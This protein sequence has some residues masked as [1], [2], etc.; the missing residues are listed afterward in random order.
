MFLHFNLFLHHFC[1]SYEAKTVNSSI[2][3]RLDFKEFVFSARLFPTDFIAAFA[4]SSNIWPKDS[5]ALAHRKIWRNLRTWVKKRSWTMFTNMKN[6]GKSEQLWNAKC[7][8]SQTPQNEEKVRQF[9]LFHLH[10]PPPPPP[11]TPPLPAPPP[12][13]AVPPHLLPQTLPVQHPPLLPQ[14]PMMT[15]NMMGRKNCNPGSQN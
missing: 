15:K 7:Q 8:I 4:I 9:S 11:P 5:P 1:L 14:I 3:K 13:L 6:P 10:P 2:L 12:Q